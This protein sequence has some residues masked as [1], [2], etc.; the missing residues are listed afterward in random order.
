[1]I[2]GLEAVKGR[3]EGRCTKGVAAGAL[4]GATEACRTWKRRDG[5]SVGRIIMGN[6]WLLGLCESCSL[7]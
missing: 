1:M 3:A 4:A 5:M 6:I 7:P 2:E